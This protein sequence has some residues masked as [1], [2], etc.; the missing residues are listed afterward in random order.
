M[1]T[2]AEIIARA[3]KFSNDWKDAKDEIAEKQ[4]FWDALFLVYGTPRKNVAQYEHRIKYEDGKTGFI[5]LLWKGKLLVEQ[6]SAGKDLAIARKEAQEYANCLKLA[7]R[8]EWLVVSDFQN[9]EV[10]KQSDGSEYKFQLSELDKNIDKLGFIGGF[11]LR[12]PSASTPVN[13][14]AVELLG[15]IYDALKDG[16]Y[17]SHELPSLLVRILFALFSEDTAIFE[18]EQF[19]NLIGDFSK[20]DGSDLG[21]LLD[22]FFEV[23]NTPEDKRQKHISPELA[24]FPYVNGALFGRRLPNAAMNESMRNALLKAADFDWTQIS[25][26]IFGSLFQSVME[27]AERR[28][29]GAHY[30]SEDDI[31]KLIKPLFLDDLQAELGTIIADKSSRREAK[32]DAY[33]NKI[34]ALKFLDPAC[35]CGNFLIIAY[36]ELRKLET[37]LLVERYKGQSAGFLDVSLF[38]KLNVDDMYGIEIEEFPAEIAKVGMWL[39]DHICNRELA[40]AFGKAFTRLPLKT[41]ATIVCANALTTDWATVIAPDKCAYIMGNP[42]FS[43]ARVMSV[44][45]KAELRALFPSNTLS[46]DMDYVTGWYL[47]AAA[48]VDNRP[49]DCAFVSTNSITQGEQVSI[50]WPIILGRGF[51]IQFAHRTFKWESEARGAAHVHVVIVGFSKRDR[52]NKQIFDH[53]G[54]GVRVINAQH[55]SPYLIDYPSDTTV[56]SRTAPLCDVP[57]IAM[58]NQPIDNGNYIFTT[59]EK[60]QFLLIE[61]SAAPYFRLFIGTRELLNGSDRWILWLGDCKPSQLKAMPKVVERVEAVRSYRAAS[62]RDQTKAKSSM[63]TRYMTENIPTCPYMA[64]PE[65]SSERRIYMPIAYLTPDVFSSNKI[66]LL[67]NASLYPI[68]R[69]DVSYAQCVDAASYRQA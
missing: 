3:Q 25:P 15:D 60:H 13:I 7:D 1:L 57:K 39:M 69:A 40:A 14:K 20:D 26:A 9:F 36:R 12:M 11:T 19:R 38:V 42:P 63:P 55:I 23:L 16:G 30:T 66:R 54:V 6:K 8:P 4:S 24:A 44:Q 43:G 48:Y 56:R 33:H 61:P 51:K 34:A 50:L 62:K 31:L 64:L 35:G 65:V 27:G 28:A 58:G 52:K 10:I 21:S 5:D 67:P 45:Q 41:S 37:R 49:I 47:K 18:P 22:R 59:E 68:R 53:D 29:L 2:K 46:G 32:L 17:P